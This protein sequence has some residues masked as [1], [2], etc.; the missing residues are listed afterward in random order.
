M[1]FTLKLHVEYT[2][3][4]SMKKKTENKREINLNRRFHFI[5][6]VNVTNEAANHNLCFFLY[7]NLFV[8]TLE[9]G[10]ENFYGAV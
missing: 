7:K 3:K 10:V 6:H 9:F 8:T 5:P 1:T 2:I 4:L